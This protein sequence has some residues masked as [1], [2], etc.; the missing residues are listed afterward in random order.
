VTFPE[1]LAQTVKDWAIRI[2]I[3][4]QVIEEEYHIEA[5]Y[6]GRSVRFT[7]LTLT[8]RAMEA[9]DVASCLW[10]RT[11]VLWHVPKLEDFCKFMAGEL[12][13]ADPTDPAEIAL[14]EEWRRI[15]KVCVEMFGPE[16]GN[17]RLLKERSDEK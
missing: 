17:N 14:Y 2:E 5:R 8:D 9:V 12:N 11:S 4:V 1:L 15:A 6:N 7:T 10:G 3:E 16:F 13:Q